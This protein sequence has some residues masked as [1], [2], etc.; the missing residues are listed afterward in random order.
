V[1]SVV[2]EAAHLTNHRGGLFISRLGVISFRST[3]LAYLRL[4]QLQQLALFIADLH[5]EAT[6][7][8]IRGPQN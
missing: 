1:N 4:Y 2:D 7:S 3:T 6:F 8:F 5:N